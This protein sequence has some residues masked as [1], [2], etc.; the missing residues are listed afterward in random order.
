MI[1]EGSK[2]RHAL[3]ALCVLGCSLVYGNAAQAAPQTLLGVYQESGREFCDSGG[4]SACT[5]KFSELLQPLKIL[6]VSCTILTSEGG[7]P[8]KEI[9]GVI[10]GRVSADGTKWFP[11]PALAPLQPEFAGIGQVVLNLHVNTLFAVPARFRPALQV[12]RLNGPP[13][14]ASCTIAGQQ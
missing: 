4:A 14:S 8:S 2:V 7:S 13:V 3:H 1:A 9:T 5:V 10:L 11:G 12:S 6:N